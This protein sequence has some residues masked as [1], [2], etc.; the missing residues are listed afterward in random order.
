M[1]EISISSDLSHSIGLFGQSYPLNAGLISTFGYHEFGDPEEGLILDYTTRIVNLLVEQYELSSDM[2]GSIQAFASE[3]QELEDA[4][5]ELLFNRSLNNAVGVQLD[6]VGEIVGETRQGR[7]DDDYRAGIRFRIFINKSSGEIETLGLFVIYL[8]GG[9]FAQII[10]HY[11]AKV[12]IIF[13]AISIPA[14]MHQLVND[15]A[16]AGVGILLTWQ[17]SGGFAFGFDGEGGIPA[18]TDVRGFEE[19]NV[20]IESGKFTESIS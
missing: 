14:N 3:V 20:S 4:G 17:T 6:G 13:N 11:P 9:T 5:Q 12:E 1:H 16:A 15:V 19:L 7:S 10:E 18:Q 2:R 8:T